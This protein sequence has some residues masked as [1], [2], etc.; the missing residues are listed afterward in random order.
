MNGSTNNQ[1]LEALRY[2]VARETSQVSQTDRERLVNI[3]DYIFSAS[4]SLES[5]AAKATMQDLANKLIAN[6]DTLARNDGSAPQPSPDPGQPEMSFP[7]EGMSMPGP[8]AGM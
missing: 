8:S 4:I 5:A 1:V 3:A 6:A 2:R 7:G